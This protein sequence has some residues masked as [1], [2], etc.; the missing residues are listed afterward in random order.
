MTPPIP[1][2]ALMHPRMTHPRQT[3]QVPPRE[4]EPTASTVRRGVVNQFRGPTTVRLATLTAPMRPEEVRAQPPP[5]RGVVQIRAAKPIGGQP[6]RRLNRRVPFAASAHLRVAG[7]RRH[8]TRAP[9][10][11]RHARRLPHASARWCAAP[12][13]TP[14][15]RPR[16]HQPPETRQARE[17]R[18]PRPPRPV[19]S[20]STDP[21]TTGPATLE[22]APG[23]RHIPRS[24]Q[25]TTA[26]RSAP[27]ARRRAQIARTRG[28]RASP[29]GRSLARSSLYLAEESARL[30][31]SGW[32]GGP[33][34]GATEPP[35][36][37]CRRERQTAVPAPRAQLLEH[38]ALGR[39]DPYPPRR[40]PDPRHCS[41][42]DFPRQN[43]TSETFGCVA[44]LRSR[45]RT[46]T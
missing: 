12:S 24:A 13:R 43:G 21:A 3:A 27:G 45:S 11:V 29:T 28:T 36:R 22:R 44:W 33:A 41:R 15:D 32:P 35:A 26:R 23:R 9:R 1:P 7:T 8:R 39:A 30:R 42:H 19:R 20:Q 40:Q 25:G 31:P 6:A 37:L 16:A 17:A 34:R 5:R 10:S 4:E 46:R 2:G 38:L 14:V 18:G